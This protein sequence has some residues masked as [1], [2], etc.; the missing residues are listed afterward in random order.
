MNGFNINMRRVVAAAMVGNAL[1]IYDLVIY[2]YFATIIATHFFPQQDK[3][4]AIA[5]TF[6]IF[7]IGYLARPLGA[8]FFGRM[9]DNFGRK[10]AL[11][12]SITL[13]ALSTG[14]I[15][16]LPDYAAMGMWATLLLLVL[17]LLQGFSCG[18][19][20]IGSMIFVIEHAPRAQRGFYGSFVEA[21]LMSGLLLASLVAYLIHTNFSDAVVVAWAWRL[22]FLS[23][24]LIGWIGL[25]MRRRV[26][27]TELFQQT[28]RMPQ[29]YLKTYREYA[30]H[31]PRTILIIGMTLFS[32]VLSYLIYVFLVT[33]MSNVLHYTMRQALS[34]NIVSITLL[35][36]LMPWVGKLSDHIG[37]RPV[38]VLALIG[39]VIWIW[40]Y[41]SLLQQHNLALALLA[42]CVMT[43]FATAYIAIAMVTSIEIVP[44]HLRFTVV[45][46]AYAITLSLFGGMTPLVATLLLKT[47]HSYLGLALLLLICGLISLITVYK[48][49]ETKPKT[50]EK[51]IEESISQIARNML[52]NGDS[53]EKVAAVTGLSER[54]VT[55]M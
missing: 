2:G 32:C 14:G 34:V 49:R 17:R 31:I 21:G 6:A 38:M 45:A 10:P 54:E 8:L 35:V 28:I 15:G 16:L 46:F 37:R 23:G 18:G 11:I 20:L 43:I 5:S 55:E 51:S 26:P 33:Y 42:Q 53:V 3:F 13:M 52:A 40:P 36:L 44:T 9:G 39:S 27:E 41:F 30:N 19:E 47:T 12:T 4:T 7:F 24:V 22:S 50:I 48:V 1:E 29:H 25:F